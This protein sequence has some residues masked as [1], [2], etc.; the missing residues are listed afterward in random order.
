MFLDDHV[1]G[2]SRPECERLLASTNVGRLSLSIDALPAVLPVNYQYLGGDIIIGM[3]DGPA[4]RGIAHQPVVGLGV[5]NANW[6]D[7]PWAVLVLG[8]ATNV[9]DPDEHAQFQNLGLASPPG[10]TYA[11]YVRL[12]PDHL[13]GYNTTAP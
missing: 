6:T 3:A 1:D 10:R 7:T 12:Q 4:L 8:R 9:T 5:D 13:I 11:H 2:L